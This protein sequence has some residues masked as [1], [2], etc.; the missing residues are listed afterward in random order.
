M[1]RVFFDNI[2]IFDTPKGLEDFEEE[3]TRDAEVYGLIIKYP[4]SLT[5]WGDAYAYIWQKRKDFDYCGRIDIRLEFNPNGGIYSR[6]INAYI[7][8]ADL[9][10]NHTTK[11]IDVTIE[12]NNFGSLIK[13]NS[14]ALISPLGNKTRNGAN[15]TPLSELSLNLFNAT[16]GNN[17]SSPRKLF[18]LEDLFEYVISFLS[19]NTV[20][21][22]SDY[23][24]NLPDSE[25]IAIGSGINI[26]S[27]SSSTRVLI[28]FKELMDFCHKKHNLWFSVEYIGTQPVFRLEHES[29]FY[30]QQG[31]ISLDFVKDL[32]ESFNQEE[33]FSTIKV[34]SKD[35]IKDQS[36]TYSLPYLPLLS[37]V[38]ETYFSEGNCSVDIERDIVNEL[39]CDHNVIFDILN[40]GE[41]KYDDKNI[42]IQ[43]VGA[44]STAHKG[45]YYFLGSAPNVRYYNEQMLNINV[46]QRFVFANNLAQYIDAS[47]DNNMSA[48]NAAT[49]VLTNGTPTSI[50]T[51]LTSTFDPSSR[52]DNGTY[53]YELPFNAVV[54]PVF[55]VQVKFNSG[56]SITALPFID[57]TANIKRYN[58]S[59]VLQ[60]TVTETRT[61]LVTEEVTFSFGQLMYMNPNDYINLEI[62]TAATS[63]NTLTWNASVI[64]AF[65]RIGFASIGGGNLPIASPDEVKM[66]KFAYEVGSSLKDWSE[67]CN[68]LKQ[69]VNINTNGS[70]NTLA[71][72][73]NCKRKV[74]TGETTWELITNKREYKL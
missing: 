49:I 71:W 19:D 42:A 52:W 36:L 6:V 15:I 55:Q 56:T 11:E 18:D 73:S 9:T 35:A 14:K 17:L 67:L 69:G 65:F 16:T 62:V 53:R 41:V 60:E 43:Y 28:S 32:E 5:F 26:R 48:E 10:L 40:N 50:P 4:L 25:R 23:L 54:F 57:V 63:V 45:T 27:A 31:N 74:K 37:F 61:L 21:F 20:N 66:I 8:T 70:N 46:L 72:V 68:D 13:Q 3:I 1:V 12:D 2:E 59:N 58:S 22:Q 7:I 38:E 29:Y 51:P 33:L 47:T 64:D 24:S 44:T 34:G 39:I 30:G